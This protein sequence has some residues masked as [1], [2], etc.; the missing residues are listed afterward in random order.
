MNFLRLPFQSFLA[1][2][3]HHGFARVVRF[4][5][6]SGTTGNVKTPIDMIATTPPRRH[7]RIGV[8]ID[9]LSEN[10]AA[11]FYKMADGGAS[12]LPV[13][14]ISRLSFGLAMKRPKTQEE[15]TG[16][17]A[18]SRSLGT[19]AHVALVIVGGASGGIL[20]VAL[21]AAILCVI[22]G[23]CTRSAEDEQRLLPETAE[24]LSPVCDDTF[25]ASK[26][27]NA[28]Y[29]RA[30]SS[31]G[32]VF[33]STA[34]RDSS[35]SNVGRSG[36]TAA[37]APWRPVLRRHSVGSTNVTEQFTKTST[38]MSVVDE[39]PPTER[40]VSVIVPRGALGDNTSATVT[41]RTL[42][43]PAIKPE[44]STSQMQLSPVIECSAAG[45]VELDRPIVLR[46]PCRTLSSSVWRM[47][48]LYRDVRC[49]AGTL[50]MY[51]DEA[52]DGCGNCVVQPH[53]GQWQRSAPRRYDHMF[54]QHRAH[55]K[56]L[57]QHDNLNDNQH[58]V[59]YMYD[60]EYVCIQTR[61]LT[62][63]VCVA[64]PRSTETNAAPSVI[65]ATDHINVSTEK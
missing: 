58:S 23:H 50:W 64:W 47:G 9:R 27:C 42:N 15:E 14:V 4:D 49:V 7:V 28:T 29:D 32:A 38:S 12:T 17:K 24:K 40:G 8:A 26:D 39:I 16:K 45:I 57:H 61:H 41:V 25:L 65:P 34:P 18:M 33:T 52:G 51:A 59:L 54:R 20:A 2:A 55:S 44:S 31:R 36:C 63:F 10:A 37:T 60:D 1:C 46:I 19:V 5:T 30:D 3:I 13:P 62:S 43:I 48:V 53:T 56:Q 6:M 35:R 22:R 21:F 11:E